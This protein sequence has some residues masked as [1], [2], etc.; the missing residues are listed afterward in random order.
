LNYYRST[1]YFGVNAYLKAKLA[2]PDGRVSTPALLTAGG[3]AGN[4]S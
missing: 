2:G 1:A 4:D 3:V